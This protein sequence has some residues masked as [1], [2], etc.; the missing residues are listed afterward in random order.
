MY[1]KEELITVQFAFFFFL[2][3][4][5]RDK[6]LHIMCVEFQGDTMDWK[7]IKAYIVRIFEKRRDK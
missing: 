4:L 3:K 2:D 7:M 5:S 6:Q 1:T